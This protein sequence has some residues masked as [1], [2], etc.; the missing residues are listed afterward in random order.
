M[1][2]AQLRFPA[3]QIAPFFC[4]NCHT[5]S[6]LW[7]WI[8]QYHRSQAAAARQM[9]YM[10]SLFYYRSLFA[11]RYLHF[12]TRIFSSNCDFSSLFLQAILMCIDHVSFLLYL[13]IRFSHCVSWLMKMQI[14]RC[15]CEQCMAIIMVLSKC[16]FDNHSLWSHRIWLP[17]L[18]QPCTSKLSQVY[19]RHLNNKI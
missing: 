7:W 14:S 6:S 2:L 8:C 4:H 15:T 18:H 3:W 19:Y 5:Q 12:Y 11:P 16:K 13:V 10:Q 17:M 9:S 1:L